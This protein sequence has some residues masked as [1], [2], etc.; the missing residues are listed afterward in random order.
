MKTNFSDLKKR[1]KLEDT[2]DTGFS[3]RADYGEEDKALGS[4]DELEMKGFEE[5]L[6]ESN[7]NYPDFDL[8][9]NIIK[10]FEKTS[11]SINNITFPF[12]KMLTEPKD[13]KGRM[14]AEE[15]VSNLLIIAEKIK[16][17]GNDLKWEVVIAE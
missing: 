11:T 13:G 14:A 5:S 10:L 12:D 8:D 17:A 7:S 9:K 1:L 3:G 6:D 16:L 2:V 4:E 15:T